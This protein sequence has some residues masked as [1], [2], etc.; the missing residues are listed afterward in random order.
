RATVPWFLSPAGR[1]NRSRT[2]SDPARPGGP[3]LMA[4]TARLTFGDQAIDMPVIEGT[5]GELAL[6]I[7]ALRARTGLIAMD[8]G[9]SDTGTCKSGITDVDGEKG[10]LRY[11]GIP[12]E[13][14][15]EHSSFVETSFL[16]I[17]GHLPTT[18]E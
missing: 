7:S 9:L 3:G 1:Y 15:A 16:L 5:A 8:P 11:R 10:I 6:D 12:I 13:Q 2:R 14:L 17:Y 18:E 4:R